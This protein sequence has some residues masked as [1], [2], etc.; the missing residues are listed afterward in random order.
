MA[1]YRNQ[2][3]K[4]VSDW[5]LDTTTIGGKIPADFV[6]EKGANGEAL[7]IAPLAV[8]KAATETTILRR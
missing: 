5:T 8:T 4:I 1:Y 3:R 7:S 2:H 6:I